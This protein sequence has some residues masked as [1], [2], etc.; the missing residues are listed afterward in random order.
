[1]GAVVGVA[2]GAGRGGGCAGRRLPGRRGCRPRRGWRGGR[3][4]ARCRC[5]GP[6]GP[7]RRRGWPGGG[8]GRRPGGGVPVP[9]SK[10]TNRLG[11]RA[12]R[13]GQPLVVV[14][15][16]ARRASGPAGSHSAAAVRPGVVWTM[17]LGQGVLDVDAEVAGEDL[18]AGG[19][20]GDQPL[21]RREVMEGVGDDLA[22]HIRCRRRRRGPRR[23]AGLA[24]GGCCRRVIMACLRLAGAVWPVTAWAPSPIVAY[25]LRAAEL[26]D[27]PPPQPGGGDAR[28]SWRAAPTR[29]RCRAGRPAGW[30]SAGRPGRRGRSAGWRP[31]RGR[32]AGAR[33]SPRAGRGRRTRSPPP[34]SAAS[35]IRM[36]NP[37][38]VPSQK[39]RS[40]IG[41]HPASAYAAM[42]ARPV[43]L[44]A[45]EAAL[46]MLL[47]PV[48]PSA[49]GSTPSRPRAKMYRH[50][51]CGTP[52]RRR[53]AGQE[54]PLGG[55]GQR[56][57]R[58]GRTAARGPAPP[59]AAT[60]WL[61]PAW[62]AMAQAAP[63]YT[64]A[65]TPSAM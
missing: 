25:T 59:A 38:V 45:S 47:P 63:A 30:R 32:S 54:Q 2:V 18:A 28:R 14:R 64:T 39:N 37:P 62:A 41:G 16:A 57:C 1:M 60:T 22:E 6:A 61:V 44:W 7:G 51:R 21:G 15:R 50:T 48:R 35:R 24:G 8:A 5:P 55:L 27:Q 46:G 23:Q 43:T 13:R 10:A 9:A 33:R 4:A 53:T 49:A 36:P 20:V 26:E 3:A 42:T 56:R 40:V 12:G 17:P 29:P 19:R 52:A 58:R 65:I 11:P 34:T 31:G